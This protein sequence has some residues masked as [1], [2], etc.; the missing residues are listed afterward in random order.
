L[1][2]KYV[3]GHWLSSGPVDGPEFVPFDRQA[4]VQTIRL[5]GTNWTGTAYTADDTTGDERRRARVFHFCLIHDAHALCGNTPVIW[6]ANPKRNQLSKIKAI[7]ESVYFIDTPSP[8]SASVASSA[9]T[10]NQ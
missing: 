7:L 6:L 1:D 3:D 10:L 8:A 5:K 2:A 9:P 4:H